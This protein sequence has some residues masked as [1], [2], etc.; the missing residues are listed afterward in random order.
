MI[1]VVHNGA[2]N[3]YYGLSTDEKPISNNLNGSFFYEIDSGDL[4]VYDE[5]GSSWIKRKG[6]V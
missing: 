2:F 4:Y 1:T 5:E 6:A 3:E